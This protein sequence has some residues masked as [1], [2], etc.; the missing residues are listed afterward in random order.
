ML[1]ERILMSIVFIFLFIKKGFPEAFEALSSSE[2]EWPTGQAIR[3]KV[4]SLELEDW[5]AI[6]WSASGKNPGTSLSLMGPHVFLLFFVLFF[7]FVNERER[8]NKRKETKKKEEHEAHCPDLFL[9]LKI[10]IS[11]AFKPISLLTIIIWLVWHER[12]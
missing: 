1:R 6:N 8:E 7:P 10:I 2:S 9:F 4:R 11:H 3:P 12:N 5:S